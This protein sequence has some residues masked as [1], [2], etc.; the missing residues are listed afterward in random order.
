VAAA[1]L[2]QDLRRRA[3]GAEPEPAVAGATDAGSLAER[4]AALVALAVGGGTGGEAAATRAVIEAFATSPHRRLRQA[5]A[6]A[7]AA[8]DDA[9]AAAVVHRLLADPDP[10]VRGAALSAALPATVDEAA[11]AGTASAALRDDRDPGVRA[12]AFGWL[13][14][15]PVLAYGEL[16][17]AAGEAVR[18]PDPEVALAAVEALAARGAAVAAERGGVVAVLEQLAAHREWLVRRR[19][20]GALGDLGR[21]VPAVPGPPQR[22]PGVYQQILLSTASAREVE[23]ATDSGVLSV[24]L[25]CPRVPLTC[26]NFLQLAEQGFF[27][28]LAFHRVVPDFVV[29]DG[30]PRGDG[31]GG[32]G[33]A[34]R[35]EIS[36][37]RYARGTLGMALAGPDTGGSQFFLTLAPQPHLD[38]GYTAFG[39]V[40]AGEEVLDRILPGTVIQRI[41]EV[42]PR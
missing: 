26:L 30:D 9:T 4:A 3:G 2:G 15:H 35:D 37:L 14:E 18:S 23:I 36:P 10:A 21:P 38:G 6:T 7:A 12:V 5:A 19:A 34:I 1:G 40:V 20:A 22:A 24:S 25:D 11:A 33:Y 39:R 16:T 29:Q 42:A 41:R 27:D 13:T 31:Y 28:G 32:P 17:A 8:L